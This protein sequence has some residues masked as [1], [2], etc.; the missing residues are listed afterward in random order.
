MNVAETRNWTESS[1]PL[2]SLS[3]T[4]GIRWGLFAAAPAF[5]LGG[6]IA[7]SA[8]KFVTDDAAAAFA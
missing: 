3:D 8:A 6:L 5:A 1:S 4:Y 7:T 2:G